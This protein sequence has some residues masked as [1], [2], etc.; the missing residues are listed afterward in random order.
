MSILF[1]KKLNPRARRESPRVAGTAFLSAVLLSAVLVA[2]APAPP[3]AAQQDQ[4]LEDRLKQKDAELQ[5][6]REEIA[7]ERRKI[8]EVEKR[9]RDVSDYIDKL[10]NEERLTKRLLNGLSEKE[11]MLDE[12]VQG[13]RRDLE[14]SE[15][16]YRR[17]LTIL[18]RRLR[19]MYEDG[20]RHAWQELLQ[21]NDFADLLQRYKF[22]TAIAERD[23]NLVQEVRTRKI[24]VARQEAALTEKL[25]EVTSARQEKEHELARLKENE[26]KRQKSLAELKTSKGKYQRRI[27]E[28]AK[29]EQDLQ[30]II[31]ALEKQ[32][33]SA[34]PAAWEANAERDFQALRG[35]ML[36]PVAGPLVRGFGESRHPEFKTVTFNPG[37]DI[38]A[39]AGSAVRA[40]AKGK[41]EY[42]SL[43]PGLGN[44]VIIAHG[45]GYYTLYVHAAKIFV[46][47]GAMV[48]G[49]DIIA[50]TGSAEAGAGTPFHFEIRKSKKPLDPTEWLKK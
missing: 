15:A 2:G 34:T 23:A 16:I 12:R 47:Q 1:A 5:K 44:C 19:E 41:V 26:R 17:R 9:E 30:G 42:A 3:V 14:T 27:Q 4:A 37:I 48:A 20:P 29:A 18:S 43:M 28:L 45:Q 38:E 35:R 10:Q 7:S 33:T 39:R 6:L 31:G 22:V 25:Q 49:G 40:V 13:L 21:A 36:P 24:D 32:R 8:E 46:K 11:G 50:E